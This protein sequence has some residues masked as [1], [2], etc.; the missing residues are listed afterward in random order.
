MPIAKVKLPD[1][2]IGR[3][4]VPEGTTPEQVIA[5]AQEQLGQAI[6]AQEEEGFLSQ[7]T[8]E[9]ISQFARPLLEGGGALGGAVI[10]GG[11]GTVAAPG[12]GTLAGAVVGSGLG[13]AAGGE[14]ADLLDQFLGLEEPQPLQ[15][16]LGE[17]GKRVATGAAFEGG[18]QV[19]GALLGPA[20]SAVGRQAKKIIPFTKKAAERQ[21]GNILAANTQSGPVIAKNIDEAR[22]LE[23]AIPGLKFELGQLTD[24]A[25]VIKLSRAQARQPGGL[26]TL[27]REQTAANTEAI[28]NFITKTKGTGTIDDTTAILAGKRQVIEEGAEQAQ[29]ALGSEA[30][31]LA[32]GIAPEEGGK[33]VKEALKSGQKQAKAIAGDLF[34]QVPEVTLDA[35]KLVGQVD[36]IAKP[37]SKFESPGNVPEI[38][39]RVQDTLKEAAGKIGVDDLQGLS[40]EIGAQIGDIQQAAQPNA[41]ILSRLTRLKGAVE[42]V[43]SQEGGGTAGEQLRSAR[44]FFKEEV[45]QKFKSGTVKDI[46]RK[47]PG[48][49]DR[50]DS[51]VIASKF[52]RP[53][54]PGIQAADD[55]INA[56]GD[57]PEARAA[58][59]D[60]IKQDLLEKAASPLTGEITEGG[61]KRWL[62]RNKPA[63]SRFGLLDEFSSTVK[64]RQALDD[65]ISIK[66]AFDK[67]AAARI[68]EADPDTVIKTAFSRGPKGRAARDLLVLVREDPKA[69]AGVQNATIDHIISQA[70]T[71]AVDVFQ[72]PILSVASLDKQIKAFEPALNILYKNAPQKLT[73]LKQVRSALRTMQRTAK[74]PLGGGS[75]TAENVITAMAKEGGLSGSRLINFAR[76]A[77]KPFRDMSKEQVDSVLNRAILDPDFA[78]TILQASKGAKPDIIARRLKGHLALLAATPTKEPTQ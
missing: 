23:D 70:E 19:V 33:V 60:F 52:F 17:A 15:V 40:S 8:K 1:G 69:L 34:E 24:E 74:S 31:R 56:V 5:F 4:N 11:G 46:L 43:L 63:L 38:V 61:L 72:Q 13:L 50:V 51:A 30:E 44:K 78:F 57:N 58:L 75:D 26:A 7:G 77:I 62:A 67:S 3:F 21:A 36:E 49:V 6:P 54:K 66:A 64:A 76:A 29:R 48:G 10:G 9:T 20:I 12:P 71:T 53:G 25:G 18:G 14:L 28:R 16:E 65:A 2:R 35:S 37:F 73:A 47:G 32:A 45:I 55:F 41:R 59:N 22:A 42:D 39:K 27:Q 68:L